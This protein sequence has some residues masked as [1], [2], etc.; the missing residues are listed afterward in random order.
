MIICIF[1]ISGNIKDVFFLFIV[2][3]ITVNKIIAKLETTVSNSTIQTVSNNI[4]T[5]LDLKELKNE[6]FPICEDKIM[7]HEEVS[8]SV[9][10]D[11][12]YKEEKSIVATKKIIN[13]I[14]R[15]ISARKSKKII[16]TSNDKKEN[17]GKINVDK[18]AKKKAPTKRSYK[19][20]SKLG[21]N[22]ILKQQ[23]ET[24]ENYTKLQLYKINTEGCLK[25][26]LLPLTSVRSETTMYDTKF[27]CPNIT[28]QQE[29]N[30]Y[31]LEN[32]TNMLQNS[33]YNNLKYTNQQEMSAAT[34]WVPVSKTDNFV[35][36]NTNKMQTEMGQSSYINDNQHHACTVAA[37][38]NWKQN[39]NPYFNSVINSTSPYKL[40]PENRNKTYYPCS[41]YSPN[42]IW[43]NEYMQNFPRS[44]ATF[45]QTANNVLSSNY[46]VLPVN[47]S[48]NFLSPAVRSLNPFYYYPP[49]LTDDNFKKFYCTSF[50]NNGC[51]LMV[52]KENVMPLLDN[53]HHS[54]SLRIPTT[55]SFN[56]A[57]TTPM[58]YNAT[59]SIL[60]D[61]STSIISDM[62]KTQFRCEQ[63]AYLTNYYNADMH[64]TKGNVYK[65]QRQENYHFSSYV[66]P[67]LQNTLPAI[68]TLLNIPID[69][70]ASESYQANNE[71]TSILTHQNNTATNIDSSMM[72]NIADLSFEMAAVDVPE[73]S[74]TS[75][76]YIKDKKVL[77]EALESIL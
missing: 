77:C 55:N 42:C 70:H 21:A 46:T 69:M 30:Q 59:S 67:A 27:S 75:C 72:S 26:N 11:I 23:D 17:L 66:K 16:Q 7:K 68:T 15:R 12:T 31:A 63:N 43:N 39:E 58:W 51:E 14:N 49:L 24:S 41:I 20:L 10:D 4:D 71:L 25:C 65:D 9:K 57:P 6:P 19:T 47:T 61:A 32:N 54:N 28:R 8:T 50:N 48:N 73:E 38:Y 64:S 33:E 74:N 37:D 22:K 56:I 29:L 35:L 3:K 76:M 18:V 5:N 36:N 53:W 62:D 60:P 45:Q 2:D 13:K 52:K 1:L 44:N 34:Y 40:L